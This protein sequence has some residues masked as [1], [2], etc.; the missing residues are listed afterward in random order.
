M[1]RASNRCG[2]LAVA[3]LLAACVS[4]PF[5]PNIPHAVAAQRIAPWETYEDCTDIQVG[6]RIDFRFDATEKVDFDLYYRQGVA[7]L[8]PLSREQL[9]EDSGVFDARIPGHYCLAWKAGPA[10]AFVS[11]H[12]LVR[13]P[14]R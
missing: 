5:P 4:A 9:T 2:A 3:L 8:I 11:Y 1:I 12:V 7:V 6:D 14:Q 13:S 10:G